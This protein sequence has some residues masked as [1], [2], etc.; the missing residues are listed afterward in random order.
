[1]KAS[2]YTILYLL[3]LWALHSNT[4]DEYHYNTNETFT[5]NK[6]VR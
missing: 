4:I 3:L 2:N 5:D 1:M 6:T